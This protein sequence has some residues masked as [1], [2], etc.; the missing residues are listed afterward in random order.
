MSQEPESPE[1]VV[2]R[3]D[4][5]IPEACEPFPAVEQARPASR[6]EATAVDPDEHRP[7]GVVDSASPDV[8]AQAVLC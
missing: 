7:P 5:D 6:R 8:E 2:D 4:H 1:A 3:D